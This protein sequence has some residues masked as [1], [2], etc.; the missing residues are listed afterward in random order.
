MQIELYCQYLYE[1]MEKL[2]DKAKAEHVAA[3]FHGDRAFREISRKDSPGCGVTV[4]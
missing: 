4:A 3:G 2:A 1:V